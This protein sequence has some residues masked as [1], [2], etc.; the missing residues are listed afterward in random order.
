MG[1]RNNMCLNGEKFELHRIGDNLGVEKYS[2]KDPNENV[3]MEKKYINDLG[4]YLSNDLTWTRQ[5]DEVESGART[6]SGWALRTFSIMSVAFP[7]SQF[8]EDSIWF[9]NWERVD[10]TFIYPCCFSGN[11]S[12]SSKYFTRAARIIRSKVLII[13]EVSDT[14]L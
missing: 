4:V 3:I 7:S 2:Y 5:I 8:L 13:W 6:M 10:L 12:L 9:N 14:G 1:T 11:K